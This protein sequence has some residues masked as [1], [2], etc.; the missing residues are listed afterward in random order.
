MNKKKVTIADKSKEAR[1]GG[2]KKGKKTRGVQGKKTIAENA[3]L[4]YGHPNLTFVTRIGKRC[5]CLLLIATWNR[6]AV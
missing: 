4:N 3:A 1:Q 2:G 5:S 6:V